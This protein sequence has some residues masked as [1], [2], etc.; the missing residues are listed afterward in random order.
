MS[1]F[2]K[3]LNKAVVEIAPWFRLRALDY[4]EDALSRY[5]GSRP[6]IL[7]LLTLAGSTVLAVVQL[8]R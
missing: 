2:G 1:L 7:T 5:L 6:Y 4:E 8:I 3:A